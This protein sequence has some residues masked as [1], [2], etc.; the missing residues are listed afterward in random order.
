MKESILKVIRSSAA[1]H[2]SNKKGEGVCLYYKKHHI[3][4]GDNAP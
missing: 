3:M 1:D 2:P 4:K